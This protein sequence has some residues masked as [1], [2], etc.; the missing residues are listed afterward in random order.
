MFPFVV[1][2]VASALTLLVG[3]VIGHRELRAFV[4]VKPQ[5]LTERLRVVIPARNEEHRIATTLAAVLQDAS[6][7]LEVVVYDDRSTDGTCRVV[8]HWVQKDPRV[9]LLR[10]TT[11]PA[12][13]TFGKPVGLARAVEFADQQLGRHDGVWLFLDADVTLTAGTLGGLVAVLQQEHAD[14]LSG[15]PHF[16]N[17]SVIE[18]LVVP[19][20]TALVGMRH[21]P[22][23][24]HDERSSMAFLN[25]QLILVRREALD[26]VGGFSAVNSAVLEDVALARLLKQRG[27]RL[28]LAMLHGCAQTRMYTSWSEIRDG[29]SKNSVALFGGPATTFFSAL[30]AVVLACGPWLGLLVAVGGDDPLATAIALVAFLTAAS[31]QLALRRGLRLPLWPVLVLPL[32]Y[33]LAAWV[34]LRA[35]ML[36]WTGRDVAWRGRRYRASRH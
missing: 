35:V 17:V 2:G 1:L 22:R 21:P 10:G 23:A 8:E 18:Q 7:L 12:P 27:Y 19:V 36:V 15:V 20:I 26:G 16:L 28:R 13:G 29:F 32:A 31:S 14:A 11:D 4:K 6:P 5:T 9:L 3:S 24:V 30:T 34:L 33:A 25:G